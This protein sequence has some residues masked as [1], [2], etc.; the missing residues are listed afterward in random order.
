[1]KKQFKLM[2][3]LCVLV[4]GVSACTAKTPVP[5]ATATPTE[6]T[7]P[8]DT[9]VGSPTEATASTPAESQLIDDEGRMICTVTQ[10][11]FPELTEEQTAMLSVFP[12]ITEEDW[13]K[14]PEDALLTILEYSDF[15][16]PACGAF[17][18]ELNKLMETYPE[19]VRLVFRHFPLESLHPNA[20]LAAQAAEA[21]GLQGKFW[22]MYDALFSKQSSWSSLTTEEFTD[23]LEN[24]AA[25]LGLDVDQFMADLTS[26]A[27]VTKIQQEL[28]YGTNTIGL[29]ATPTILLNGRPWSYDWSASTLGMVIE[30]L[31]YE[32]QGLY[33]ECPPWVIDQDKEYTATIK[34]EKGDIVVELYPKEAPLTVNAFVFLARAGFY[35]GITFHRVAHEFVAQAGDPSGTGI[36]GPGFEYRNE[37]SDTLNFD[38]AYMVGMAN[39]GPD[40]NGSQFFITYVPATQLSGSYT[41]FG[42][43]ISGFD[44]LEKLT[45]RD[46]Q[47]NPDA[48]AGDKIITIEIDEK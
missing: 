8:T 7:A 16:C 15:Q 25:S 21:A 1:M 37:I 39:G 18:S 11:F 24:E 5:P 44:V 46:T 43:V 48:P 35:D 19:E 36:S 33:T 32:K 10:G 45:E 12:A 34:T 13:I 27:V 28:D 9:V 3:V 31:K 17:Y 4:L 42:K 6:T 23:W 41:I 30:V 29:N 22:E 20:T 26:E 40:T 2:L 47:V 38:E 14:G